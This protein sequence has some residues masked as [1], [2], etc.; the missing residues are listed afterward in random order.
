MRK[1]LTISGLQKMK[2]ERN[3]ISMVTAYDYPSA[4]LAEEAGID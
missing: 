1:R 3:A 4:K 2:R